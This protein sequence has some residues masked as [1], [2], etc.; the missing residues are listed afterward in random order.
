MMHSFLEMS[1]VPGVPVSLR[2]IPAK[3][4]ITIHFI[5]YAYT[6]Y[7]GLLEEQTLV[8]MSLA[9][10]MPVSLRN[11]PAKYNITIH[12]IYY[13]YTFYTGLLEEQ[14]LVE[15]SLA[16]GMPVS[17]RN[18]PAKT[19]AALQDL[20]YY[21]YTFYTGLLEEQTLVEMSLAPGMPVSLRN[22]PAKYN[23]T[24]RLWTHGF[25]CILQNLRRSMHTPS[26]P[27]CLRSTTLLDLKQS[28][29]EALGDLARYH[30]PVAA[31]ISVP[32]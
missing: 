20:I 14:T 15:M 27:A 7:T 32:A 5:Y 29:L 22:I 4:N 13:A 11:I 23:I 26:T 31:M 9:P 2:N 1:L 19:S 10:G 12:F 6:F 25:H 3:Y 16:P 21:A 28:W 18:I 30:M 17:L 8:E 24:I